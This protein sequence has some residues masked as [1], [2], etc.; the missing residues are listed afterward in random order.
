VSANIQGWRPTVTSPLP[1]PARPPP[2]PQPL[3]A[4]SPT[5]L[6]P[7]TPCSSFPPAWR[8]TPR[9]QTV[10]AGWALLWGK[11]AWSARALTAA[12]LPYA[13]RTL[14]RGRAEPAARGAVRSA[15]RCW[16][17]QSRSDPRA[18]AA[19]PFSDYGL[20]AALCA[21]LGNLRF[22]GVSAAACC[23]PSHPFAAKQPPSAGQRTLQVAC[24]PCSSPSF[25]DLL[26]SSATR[27]L[28]C[29][30]S[31]WRGTRVGW[32]GGVPGPNAA[33]LFAE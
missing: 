24:L 7:S 31:F 2:S 6:R 1:P 12:P 14:C 26:C 17:R 8:H 5:A 13:A 11:A 28:R 16:L 25:L 19:A 10:R 23:A 20:V 15:R 29:W 4:A 32:G 33:M 21:A 22:E 18:R 27:C 9:C 3:C 30:K